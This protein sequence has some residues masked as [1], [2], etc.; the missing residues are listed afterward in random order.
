MQ[1]RLARRNTEIEYSI[2]CS[3]PQISAMQSGGICKRS[4]ERAD[5]LK[6]ARFSAFTNFTNVVDLAIA[7]NGKTL[8]LEDAVARRKAISAHA[9]VT[10]EAAWFVVHSAN[11]LRR[12]VVAA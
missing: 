9:I 7:Q 10:A 1:A 11:A 5:D 6:I 8:R 2:F 12:A 4:R 3:R